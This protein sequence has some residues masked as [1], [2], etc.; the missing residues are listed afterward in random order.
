MLRRMH[1]AAQAAS[2]SARLGEMGRMLGGRG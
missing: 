2:L 1:S